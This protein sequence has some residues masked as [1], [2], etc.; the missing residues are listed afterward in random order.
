MRRD[1]LRRGSGFRRRLSV[2]PLANPSWDGRGAVTAGVGRPQVFENINIVGAVGRTLGAM[3][4]LDTRVLK[5]EF[6][7]VAATAGGDAVAVIAFYFLLDP[8]LRLVWRL[9][10]RTRDFEASWCITVRPALRLLA[11]V[12]GGLY[13]LD[14]AYVVATLAGVPMPAL[15][16]QLAAAAGYTAVA[17]LGLTSIKD[18]LLKLPP[19][20]TSTRARNFA[21][22]RGSGVA[23]WLVCILACL[24]ILRFELG[25]TLGSIFAFSG[26]S[27]LALGFAAKDLAS[28][29]VGGALLFVTRPFV[30]GDKIALTNLPQSVVERIGWYATRVRCDDDQVQVVPNSKFVS[31][32]VSNLSKRRHRCIRENIHLSYDDLP[33]CGE[34]VAALKARLAE[35]PDVDTKRRFYIFI[36]ELRETDV[37]IE[38]EVHWRGVS[39]QEY[40]ERRTEALLLIAEVVREFGASFAVWDGV[41]TN[42]GDSAA[43]AGRL[44]AALD[45]SG[46]RS[47]SVAEL[48][49]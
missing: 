49:D 6:T 34:I 43:S 29:W 36:K 1:R 42:S 23:I 2:G 11:S 10:G 28:N 16:P 38:I 32:K 37:E 44:V 12:F 15:A 48:Y 30:P 31:N 13:A 35:M 7:R 47:A 22:K 24:E 39:S 4:N 46:R 41:L 25:L 33:R 40:R 18:R 27:G 45:L 20:S 5:K 26:V 14:C 8:A 9:R 21:V 17:G 3:Q 19:S